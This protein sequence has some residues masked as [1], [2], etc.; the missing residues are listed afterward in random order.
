[1]TVAPVDLAA[2]LNLEEFLRDAPETTRKAAS[3][4]MNEVIGGSGLARYR[5]AITDQ[6]NLPPSY[7]N[8]SRFGVD[9][10]ATPDNLVT[11]LIARQRPTSLA[12]FASGGAIGGK[13]GVS[14][15]VKKQGSPSFMKSAFLVR[16]KAGTAA[17]ADNF[18]V[19]LAIRLKP[20]QTLNKKDASRMV[21]LEANVVL[22]YGPSIDQILN[23]SVIEA[24]TP[25]VIDATATEFYRQFAR[26]SNG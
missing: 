22:L 3:I 14:V 23:N 1:M 11:S 24:E 18:N 6:V 7:V 20:G 5:R 9:Q 13:G 2:V 26:L 17:I 15:R 16:L 8:D 21:H 19:G 25:E 4:A 12:R 10:R